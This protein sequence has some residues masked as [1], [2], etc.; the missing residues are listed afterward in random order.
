MNEELLAAAKQV[1]WKL[2]HN[3]D[4]P[5]VDGQRNYVHGYKGPALVSRQDA[6]VQMLAAAV[7]STPN[8]FNADLLDALYLALPYVEHAAMLPDYKPAP[9]NALAARIR[10]TLR[11]AEGRA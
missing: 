4:I 8:D 6:T 3:F 9:V 1:L 2:G 10:A 11:K 5:A 7:A